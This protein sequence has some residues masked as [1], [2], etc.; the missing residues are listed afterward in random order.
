MEQL[1]RAGRASRYDVLRARVS[2]PTW[3][4]RHPG[5]GRPR[6]R[7]ARAEAPGQRPPARPPPVAISARGG[8]RAAQAPAAAPAGDSTASRAAVGARRR[9]AGPASRASSPS[10][11]PT[12]SPPSPSSW[13]RV[14]AFPAGSSFPTRG[15]DLDCHLPRR[16]GHRPHVHGQNRGSFSDRSARVQLSLP[17]FDGLAPAATSALDR[18]QAAWRRRRPRRR[19]RRRPCNW[20]R[21]RANLAAPTHVRRHPPERGRGRGGFRLASLRFSRGLS[22]QLDVATRSWPWPRREHAARHLDL[23]LAPPS[24]PRPG[25]PC[26]SRRAR[27]HAERNRTVHRFTHDHRR[28]ARRAV[29]RRMLQDAGGEGGAAR[30]RAAPAAAA[31]RA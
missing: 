12:T 24:S 27:H 1:E 18:A 23:Y 26:R 19:A 17:V 15:G 20:P 10:R 14:A 31:R 16:L 5:R 22:T 11:G 7:A 30:G 25:A 6:A 29:A 28:R 2:A 21:A 8:R 4:R 9:A 3:S 13:P